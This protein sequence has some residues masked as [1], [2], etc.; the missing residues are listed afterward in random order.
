MSRPVY[1]HRLFIAHAITS[2]ELVVDSGD[3]AVI[4]CINVF[5][6]EPFAVGSF[7]MVDFDTDATIYYNS[8]DLI[9]GTGALFV[10]DCRIVL[11]PSSRTEMLL[12]SNA[13]V[14]LN[15][16]LLTLP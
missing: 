2:A 8:A 15:G 4:R 13:D 7:Q 16:Y 9:S 1:T 12:T 5:Y 10:P 11:P 14:T 6:P 3:V